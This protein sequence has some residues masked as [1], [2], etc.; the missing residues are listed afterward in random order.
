MWEDN[1][2]LID[3]KCRRAIVFNS[4]NLIREG[5]LEINKLDYFQSGYSIE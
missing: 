5:G 3:S 4:I 2:P 1:V